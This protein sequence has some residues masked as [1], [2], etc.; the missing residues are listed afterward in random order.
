MKNLAFA[1]ALAAFACMV[2]EAWVILR[3]AGA[4]IGLS[5]AVAVETFSRVASFASSVIPAT[6]GALEASRVAAAAAIGATGGAA[7]AITDVLPVV[8][9]SET[10]TFPFRRV[11]G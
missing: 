9:P 2:L 11:L 7:R 6:L 8:L 10:E 4:P 3:A 5:G 1:V